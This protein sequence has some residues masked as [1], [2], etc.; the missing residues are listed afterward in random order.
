LRFPE[1]AVHFSWRQA[2]IVPV[3]CDLALSCC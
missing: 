3:R 1:V 2:A